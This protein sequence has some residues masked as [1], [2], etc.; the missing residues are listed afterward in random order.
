MR[1]SGWLALSCTVLAAFVAAACGLSTRGLGDD[2]VDGGL[3]ASDAMADTTT[4]D[5]GT[6]FDGGLSEA[7]TRDVYVDSPLSDAD[8]DSMRAEDGGA[9]MNSPT[10]CGPPGKCV[11]CTASSNG[12]VCVSGA[13][14]CNSS[15]DCPPP[16]ACQANHVCG[17]SCG[18]GQMPCNGGCCSQLVC[19]PFDNA[20]CGSAC[21]PCGG[22]TPTCGSDGMCNGK[23]GGAGTGICQMSCCNAGTCATVGDHTCGD[24]G[25]ACADCMGAAAGSSCEPVSAGT[26]ACGCD[27]PGNGNQCPMNTACYNLRCTTSCDGQHPCN[28]GCCSGNK[29]ASSTCVASCDAGTGCMGNMCQ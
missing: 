24:W 28:G 25:Q 27:G 2:P 15:N 4:F 14:G 6:M 1:G 12:S 21:G 22:Q 17:S 11:D 3:P 13:C 10:S 5:G 26:Y 9:C 19:V 20:H 29:I 7:E 18:T 23:C 8:P 16:G